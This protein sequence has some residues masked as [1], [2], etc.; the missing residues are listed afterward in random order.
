MS[1]DRT[2]RAK[3][4]GT[5]AVRYTIIYKLQKQ[6]GEVSFFFFISSP[7]P[8]T[9]YHSAQLTI[10]SIKV[11][12]FS[13]FNMLLWMKLFFHNHVKISSR[14]TNRQIIKEMCTCLHTHTHSH[15][16]TLI[17]ISYS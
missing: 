10:S 3:G 14:K 1:S 11:I 8:I 12:S 2:E 5:D 9:N 16:Y 4:E 17:N 6:F 15:E 13:E 7:F